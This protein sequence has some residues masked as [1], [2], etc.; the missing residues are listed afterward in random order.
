M[1]SAPLSLTSQGKVH[2]AFVFGKAAYITKRDTRQSS[3]S[4][5]LSQ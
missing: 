2:G 3:M 5:A 1:E 4:K